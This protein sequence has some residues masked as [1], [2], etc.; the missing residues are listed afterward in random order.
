V[1]SPEVL[2]WDTIKVRLTKIMNDS[3]R[4][5][6]L[7]LLEN[8][9][10]PCVHGV[11]RLRD[12]A[13]WCH[14][15]R[16]TIYRARRGDRYLKAEVQKSLSWF[17][18][19]L[20]RGRLSKEKCYDGRWRIVTAQ[21]QVSAHEANAGAPSHAAKVDWLTG[22]LTFGAATRVDGEVPD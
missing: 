18:Y 12:I 20:D 13:E 10:D 16:Q 22:K 8:R 19:L 6:Q 17:F 11:I 3:P 15:D 21:P 4:Q 2:P 14:F 9:D 5:E 1:E 7:N